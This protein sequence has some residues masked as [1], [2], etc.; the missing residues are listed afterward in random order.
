LRRAGYGEEDIAEAL[1]SDRSLAIVHAYSMNR[2]SLGQADA[3]VLISAYAVARSYTE[4]DIQEIVKDRRL[5]ACL[6]AYA[7]QPQK[8]T[9]DAALTPMTGERPTHDPRDLGS[10]AMA[11]LMREAVKRSHSGAL[12]G[13]W[14]GPSVFRGARPLSRRKGRKP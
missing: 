12:P 5:L 1:K 7:M 3:V 11:A 9:I 2:F 6:D 14:G 10:N 8:M 13:R 4:E